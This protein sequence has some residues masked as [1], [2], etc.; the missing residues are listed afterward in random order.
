MRQGSQTANKKYC[1]EI[2]RS[3]TKSWKFL[4]AWDNVAD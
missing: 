2:V 4:E 3:K 1:E